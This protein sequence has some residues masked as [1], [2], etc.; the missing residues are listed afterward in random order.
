MQATARVCD[1]AF[2]SIV[3]LLAEAGRA[4][5]AFH[6]KTVR[7]VHSKRVQCDEIWSFVYAKQRNVAAAEAAPDGAGIAGRGLR[8]APTAS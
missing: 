1:V 8:C 7:G 5:E 4:C 3:K 2:N 6:D